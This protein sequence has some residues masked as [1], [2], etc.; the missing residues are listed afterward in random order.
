MKNIVLLLLFASCSSAHID[1]EKEKQELLKLD[2]QAREFHFSKNA[3]GMADGF[4]KDFISINRG[5]I[6]QPTYDQHIQRF[7][8]YFKQVIEFIKWDNN[9]PPVIRFSEDAS[10]AYVAVDKC[11]ILKTKDENQQ[12]IVD[13]TYFAWLSVFKKINGQWVL[14]C[15]S[16]TNK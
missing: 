9:T 14:D 4:S 16:S 13:T 8:N 1:L 2:E 3:K 10:V 12:E 15:V 7:D 5:V 6:S 11:V